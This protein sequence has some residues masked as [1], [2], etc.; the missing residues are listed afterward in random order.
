MKKSGSL[1]GVPKIGDY[2]PLTSQRY[3]EFFVNLVNGQ[4]KNIWMNNVNALYFFT[5]E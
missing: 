4:A 2:E 3:A 5:M 1:L